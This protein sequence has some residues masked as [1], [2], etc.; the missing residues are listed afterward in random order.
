MEGAELEGVQHTPMCR[1]WRSR[2]RTGLRH[3][4]AAYGSIV[5]AYDHASYYTPVRQFSSRA[6]AIP[7]ALL[8][9][10]LVHAGVSKGSSWIYIGWPSK[11]G[12][13][14]PP[15]GLS[16]RASSWKSRVQ[17]S[18]ES[19][20][21]PVSEWSIHWLVNRWDAP[22]S[23]VVTG[24]PGLLLD[25]GKGRKCK[26]HMFCTVMIKCNEQR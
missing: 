24:T 23:I 22:A 17:Q 21:G 11:P 5:R 20:Y 7:G 14:K 16:I 25:T 4:A 12:S 1:R 26:K 2:L 3:G 9:S 6:P 19:V 8:Q 18:M 15:T 10:C 13:I